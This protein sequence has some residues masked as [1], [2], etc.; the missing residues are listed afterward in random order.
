ME[1]VGMRPVVVHGGGSRISAAMQKAGI[2]PNFIEG[3]RYTDA[4]TLDIVEQVLAGDVNS[5]LAERFEKIGGRAKTLNFATSPV[6]TGEQISLTGEDGGTV[7]LGFVG[8]V[9]AVD[10]S[11]ID[12]LC[13]AGQVPFIPS[14][15][16]TVGRQKLNV[17][18][19]TAAMEVACALNAEKLIMLSDVP[20]VCL[21]KGNEES[22]ISSLNAEK[23]NQLIADGTISDGMIPKVQACLET[24]ERGVSKVHICLLYTSPSPR[25][26]STSRMPSSA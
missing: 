17:N 20:G 14:M 19:D 22:L 13:C 5:E 24:L 2:E 11:V 16:E 10:C 6:L 9:S 12:E 3:R 15:A 18:A 7:D 1:T 23:A 8:T 25:D 4:A 26:L 21:E